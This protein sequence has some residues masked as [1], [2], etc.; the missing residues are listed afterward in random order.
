ML[1]YFPKNLL[2]SEL[3]RSASVLITGT[4]LAQLISILLQPVIRRLFSAESFGVF[5]VYL[6]LIGMITVVSSLRFDDAIVIP[7][8][9][10]ESI[11]LIGLSL[12]FNFVINILLFLVVII[13]RDNLVSF[14]NLPDDFPVAVLYL[15]PIGAFLVNTFQCFNSW[16]IRK[17]KFYSVSANKLVRRSS[18]GIAQISFAFSKLYNGL[19]LSDIVGQVANVAVAIIQGLKNGLNF[20]LISFAKL[21]YVFRKYSE[22]PKYNLVP[23]FMS[24][25]SYLLP[26]I[27][28]NKFFSSEAAGY[29]DLSKLLLSIPLAL[30]ASSLSSVLLQKISEKFQKGESFIGEI[31]PIIFIV[32]SISIVEI[33]A[34]ILFGDFIFRFIF[35]EAW[36]TSGSISRI[37]VWSFALNFIVSSFNSIFITMRRIKTYSVWQFFYFLAILSLLFFRHLNFTE[38]LKVYVAIEVVCYFV[39]AC[40]MIFIVT[41]FELSVRPVNER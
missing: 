7:R 31:K 30:I 20:R 37:M 2:R 14:L 25:C 39:V 15:I 18:E 5:S 38:F 17:R 36:S 8:T 19:I 11:N 35:G 41:R 16:L 28:I 9:D 1:K 34:I 21:K 12:F 23:A 40:V 6:S 10:K 3:I 26:P 27:F 33:I 22:F 32:I 13:F 24:A 29:F 4:I